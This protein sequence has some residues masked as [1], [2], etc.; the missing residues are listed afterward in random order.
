MRKIGFMSELMRRQTINTYM[1]DIFNHEG[2]FMGRCEIPS[3]ILDLTAV[4]KADKLYLV[5]KDDEGYPYI[6]V[7]VSKWVN[8]DLIDFKS[9]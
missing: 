9:R 6:G 7:Y 5:E 4:W 8:E 3:A 2:K 1:M